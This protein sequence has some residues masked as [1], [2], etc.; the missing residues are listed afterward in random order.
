MKTFIAEDLMLRTI[1][2]LAFVKGDIN[3]DNKE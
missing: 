2:A 3:S 1:V